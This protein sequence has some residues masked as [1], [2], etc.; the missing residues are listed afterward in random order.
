MRPRLALSIVAA[1]LMA[2]APALPQQHPTEQPKEGSEKEELTADELADA[3]EAYIEDDADLKG[4]YFLVFDS[5]DKK[6]LAL[7]LDKVHRD[8]LASIGNGVYFACTDMKATDGTAYDVDVFMVEDE[9]EVLQTTDIGIHKK[10]GKTR[11]TWKEEG[12][13][14]KK[15]TP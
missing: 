13:V 7:T 8:K 6:P 5:V 4:G 15:I 1:A 2:A 3:I 10:A 14:W 9:D 12:G 11:Y